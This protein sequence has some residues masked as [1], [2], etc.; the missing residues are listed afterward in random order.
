ML[1]SEAKAKPK[2]KVELF[3]PNT[4]IIPLWSIGHSSSHCGHYKYNVNVLAMY[5][6]NVV[7]ILYTTCMVMD[8]E[9][10]SVPTLPLFR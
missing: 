9:Y 7:T 2:A 8:V 6:V 10:Q 4:C 3:L 1:D 5:I